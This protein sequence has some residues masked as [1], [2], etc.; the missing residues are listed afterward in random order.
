M[1]EMSEIVK[2]IAIK[3]AR[4]SAYTLSGIVTGGTAT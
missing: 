3:E 4:D 2:S 1:S